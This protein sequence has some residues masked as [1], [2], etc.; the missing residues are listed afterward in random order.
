VL[1]GLVG[2]SGLSAV[3]CS[4]EATVGKYPAHEL[5]AGENFISSQVS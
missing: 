1:V 3:D 5:G 4:E 2:S